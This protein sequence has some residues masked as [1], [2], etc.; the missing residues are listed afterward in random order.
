MPTEA[1]LLAVLNFMSQEMY[2]AP[3]RKIL[4]QLDGSLVPAF[5]VTRNDTVALDRV[6]LARDAVYRAASL[7]TIIF[8]IHH[9]AWI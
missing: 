5:V 4:N 1:T 9:E 8:D 2:Y 6:Y 7:L 3:L